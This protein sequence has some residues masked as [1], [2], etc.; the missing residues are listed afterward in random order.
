M[1]LTPELRALANADQLT[2]GF[3]IKD[4]P[5][6][7]HVRLHGNHYYDIVVLDP[8]KGEVALDTDNDA[9]PKEKLNQP[10]LLDGSDAGGSS[11]KLGF[12]GVGLRP[13]LRGLRDG[14]LHISAV[15]EIEFLSDEEKAKQLM[16]RAEK[17]RPRIMTPEEQR[18][19]ES[20][21]GTVIKELV[22]KEF[23]EDEER[24]MEMMDRFGNR[25][26]KLVLS[27]VFYQAKRYKKM[28]LAFKLLNEDWER[29]WQFQPPFMC[30]NPEFMPLNAARWDAFFARLGVPTPGQEENLDNTRLSN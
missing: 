10:Y 5:R 23:P 9:I 11:L 19:Y 20:N 27:G 24:V 17:H 16:D 14:L 29:D 28:D 26:A 21:F 25:D 18:E 2:D 15:Q 13:R 12:V 1:G 30:G 3:F 22:H 8:E 4:L 7:T 6:G